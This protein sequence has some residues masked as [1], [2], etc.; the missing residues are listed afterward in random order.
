M[1]SPVAFAKALVAGAAGKPMIAINTNSSI[2][3][4]P[5]RDFTYVSLPVNSHTATD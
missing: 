4:K 1:S 5:K 3:V 2:S